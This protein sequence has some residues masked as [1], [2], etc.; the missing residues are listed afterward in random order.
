[1]VSKSQLIEGLHEFLGQQ[2]TGLAASNP[3]VGVLKPLITRAMNNKLKGISKALD[4]IAEED[5]SIDIESIITEMTQSLLDAQP[6]PVKTPLLGEM[7][8]GGGKIE[9][10]IPFT[11]KS[12]VFGQADLNLLKE[13]LTS[14][15]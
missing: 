13:L 3:M 1:M 8:I 2:L 6:F 14:K 10:N 12:L 11:D 4:L 15:Q 5:G 9:V 7:M